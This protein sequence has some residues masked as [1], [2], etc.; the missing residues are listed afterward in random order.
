MTQALSKTN[1]LDIQHTMGLRKPASSFEEVEQA[2]F[3]CFLPLFFKA[4][5]SFVDEGNSNASTYTRDKETYSHSSED[6]QSTRINLMLKAVVLHHRPVRV[7]GM[8][9]SMVRVHSLNLV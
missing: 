5:S 7:L 8:V 1:H 6:T 4:C 3:E 9:G 2:C